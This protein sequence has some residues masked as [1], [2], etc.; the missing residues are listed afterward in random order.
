MYYCGVPPECDRC[1]SKYAA[2]VRVT[3]PEYGEVKLCE[4]CIASL[5]CVALDQEKTKKPTKFF[6]TMLTEQATRDNLELLRTTLD[7]VSP[8][9]EVDGK[10]TYVNFDFRKDCTNAINKLN[11][12]DFSFVRVVRITG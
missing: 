5:I 6:V 7:G 4:Q 2:K 3:L 11:E 8:E 10:F 1:M 9:I 12:V